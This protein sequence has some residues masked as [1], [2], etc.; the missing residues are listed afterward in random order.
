LTQIEEEYNPE[1]IIAIVVDPKTGEILA[2]SNRPSF[3]PNQYG[4][5]TNYLNYAISDR[6]E[7]G[8][9]MK[10]FTLAAA[11]EE[12]VYNGEDKYQSGR[13]QIGPDRVSD[14]N[15]GEGWG[16][17]SYDEG[18]LRSSNVA[19]SKLALEKL[20]SQTLYEYWDSFGFTKPTGIDLPNEV[21]SLIANQYR[22]DA[23]TTAFGQGT[24]VTP[25]QQIQAATAI[26]NGGKMMKP[27]IIDQIINPESKEVIQKTEPVVVGNPIS[28]ETANHVLDLLEKV[29]TSPSG[30]GKP[31]FIEGFD[32]A[33]KTGTAQIRNPNGPGYI[34]GNG[35]NIFSFLGIAPKDDPSVIVYVAVER[36][37]LKGN[38]VGN[39]PSATIFKTIM[40]HSLQYL[41]IRP[42]AEQETEEIESGFVTKNYIGSSVEEVRK[43]VLE[44]KVDILILGDSPEIKAQQ[45]LENKGML[46]GEKLFLLT[47]SEQTKM[48]D[49]LGWSSRDVRK[50]A[51]IMEMK[52][53]I[54]GNGYL[55]NQSIEP[56]TIIQKG[57]S[58]VVDL[59]PHTDLIK[60][61]GGTRD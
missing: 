53:N 35:E 30:T 51:K 32:I 49:M 37:K 29:V 36:P 4:D 48:P 59:E 11:I 50:F 46:P 12:G 28:K 21:D 9:T 24:A 1:K 6:F 31:Y 45:P 60:K 20:G 47:D 38:E 34:E 5:I 57:D 44:S 56:G 58:F 43:N 55:K 41:N 15:R 42:N 10:M 7:P 19:F 16:F 17:I 40:K 39:E 18:F 25:I 3:N 61:K 26:A 14:H 13:Y 27:Y 8:S 52:L 33:G 23:A 54:F 22:I 2:M